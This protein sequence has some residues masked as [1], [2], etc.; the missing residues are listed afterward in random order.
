MSYEVVRYE[1]DKTSGYGQAFRKRRVRPAFDALTMFLKHCATPTTPNGVRLVAYLPTDSDDNEVLERVA[2]QTVVDF[3]EPSR[4]QD[5]GTTWPS[6]RSVKGGHLEFDL[7]PERVESVVQYLSDREPW[8]SA[9]LGPVELHFNVTF[10]WVDVDTGRLLSNQQHGHRTRDGKLW[11]S[12]LVSFGRRQ[13]VQPELWFPFPEGSPALTDYLSAVAPYLPFELHER[14]F[15]AA[16]PKIE[17]D[18]YY[19]RKLVLPPHAV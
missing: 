14:H 3:G 13:F 7:E 2:R 8:P 17:G 18:G 19:F 10:Q 6:G 12:L 9:T 15:R 5:G 16:I 1:P 11:S 4:R